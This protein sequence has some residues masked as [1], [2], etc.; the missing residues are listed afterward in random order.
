MPV[1]SIA[2]LIISD[3]ANSMH[4]KPFAYPQNTDD[5]D[6]IIRAKRC[7]IQVIIGKEG[8]TYLLTGETHSPSDDYR[9]FQQQLFRSKP[10]K[11]RPIVP[12]TKTKSINWKR[13]VKVWDR[14][15][16]FTLIKTR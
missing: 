4:K 7:G 5:D 9:L 2:T 11:R 13:M 8:A 1:V 12:V 3:S 10:I 14:I 6:S 15:G 16:K